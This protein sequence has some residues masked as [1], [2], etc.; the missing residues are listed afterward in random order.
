M[1]AMHLV[2]IHPVDVGM[3]EDF[4]LLMVLNEKV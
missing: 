2:S 4:D 3:S 1:G